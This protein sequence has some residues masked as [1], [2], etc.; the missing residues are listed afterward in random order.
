MS[1]QELRILRPGYACKDCVNFSACHNISNQDAS[2]QKC[3]YVPI[4]FQVGFQDWGTKRKD[5]KAV[6]DI[7]TGGKDWG[8]S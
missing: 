7:V 8:V 1:I 4:P 6:L 5:V 3:I 2:S